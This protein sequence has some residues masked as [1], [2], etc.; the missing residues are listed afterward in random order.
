MKVMAEMH[1]RYPNIKAIRCCLHHINLI[2][3]DISRLP[4]ARDIIKQ[5]VRLASFFTVSHFWSAQ[6]KSWMKDEG[7]V[8]HFLQTFCETRWYSLIFVCLGIL[9]FEKGFQKCL[10]LS[11]VGGYPK[12]PPDIAKIICNRFHFAANSELVKIIKPVID[13]I[14]RLEGRDATLAN[15]LQEFIYLRTMLLRF[16]WSNEDS[17]RFVQDVKRIIGVR[18]KKYDK[19]IYFVALYLSPRF[20]NIAKSKRK[21]FVHMKYA[22]FLLAKNWDFGR[23]EVDQLNV[24]LSHYDNYDIAFG[25]AESLPKEPRKYWQQIVNV[26][27]LR[28]LVLKLF[29]IVPHGA[30][31]E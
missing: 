27:S 16:S 4:Y 22:I 18:E 5:N 21:T 29:S 24:D 1:K 20:R 6:L 15:I 25:N 11:S 28:K 3:K 30:A 13:S 7:N 2:A 8:H 17:K 12:L 23:D 31:V 19:D 14:G 26:P 9:N 10:E